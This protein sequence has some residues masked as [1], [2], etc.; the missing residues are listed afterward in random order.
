[1]C[2][3]DRFWALVYNIVGIPIAAMGFLSPLVAGAAMALSLIHI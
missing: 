1:M 3:R 2:I